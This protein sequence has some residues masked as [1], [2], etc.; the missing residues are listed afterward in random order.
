MRIIAGKF[1]GRKIDFVSNEKTRPTADMVRE[2]FFCKIQFEITN[3][4]FLD[5]FAG[6]GSIGLEALSRGA[7]IV[8]FVEND[9]KNY[10][11]I[12]TNLK[13]LYGE[14]YEN[15]AKEQGQ[16][17]HLILSDFSKFLDNIKLNSGNKFDFVYI[18][19]PYESEYYKLA[20]EK[21]KNNK[22][23]TNESMV[24]CEGRSPL[25]FENYKLIS[26][27]KYGIKILSYLKFIE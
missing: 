24:I 22:L 4:T 10:E 11:I 21:L 13:K 2:A 17:I 3:S 20:L 7:K 16:T 15:Y 23:I 8:Y 27:K 12:K 9:R 25:T 1:K 5:L 19:P 26:Q 18:D 14:D 6:S